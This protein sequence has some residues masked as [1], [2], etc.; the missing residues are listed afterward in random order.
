MNDVLNNNGKDKLNNRII[1]VVVYTPKNQ[2]NNNP[3]NINNNINVNTNNNM[4]IADCWF[5]Y[6]N[7]EKLEIKFIIKNFD[8]FYVAYPKGPIDKYHFLLIPKKHI[9]SFI[10]LNKDEKI[11]G[12]M[13]IQLITDY[14]I[15]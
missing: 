14:C 2:I 9:S 8:N 4:R 11:E 1:K 10:E 13:I 12:E 15:N 7:N 3:N 6:E 5:C